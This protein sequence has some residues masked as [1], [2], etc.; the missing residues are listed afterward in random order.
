MVILHQDS[1]QTVIAN[2]GQDSTQTVIANNGFVW[3]EFADRTEYVC[4]DDE[5]DAW[6]T[7]HVILDVVLRQNR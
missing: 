3:I 1:T 5:A 4:S 2:N 6:W 7:E